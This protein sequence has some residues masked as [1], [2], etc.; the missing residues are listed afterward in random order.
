[1]VEGVLAGY[2]D[3]FA[4]YPQIKIARIVDI[5]GD[6]RVAFDTTQEIIGKEK[7]KVDGFV[8]LEAQ[9]GKE[10]ANVLDRYNVKGKTVVAMDTD[11]ETLDAIKRGTIVATIAQKPFTMAF[12]GMKLLD[13]LHHHLRWGWHPADHSQPKAIVGNTDRAVGHC[14]HGRRLRPSL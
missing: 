12:V 8:C 14:A 13:D 3:A 2:R 9:A 7:D 11:A 1:M 6:P 4:N 10:V 5:H